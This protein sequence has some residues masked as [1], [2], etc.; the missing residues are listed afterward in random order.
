MGSEKD[1]SGFYSE[2]KALLKEYIDLRL[3]LV[4]LQGIKIL[5]RSL[6][7]AMVIGMVICMILFTMLFLGMSFAWWLTD[8]TNSATIGFAGAGGLFFILLLIFIVFKKPL[9]QNPLIRY[10]IQETSG[11]LHQNED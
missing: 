7:L 9:F 6:S 8:L 1:F 10:F 5:S 11:D 3:K 2:N 4:K